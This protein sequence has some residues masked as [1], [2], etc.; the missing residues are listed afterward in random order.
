LNARRDQTN[1]KFRKAARFVLEIF[2]SAFPLVR[3]SASSAVLPNN[4]GDDLMPKRAVTRRAW[5]PDSVRTLKTLARK[6]THAAK[7][8]KTLKRTEGATR[9][10]AFSL[11]LSLDSRI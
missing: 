11:G 10:K 4:F 8:A 5:T 3:L 2:R 1:A 9:Q 6:K 7:I